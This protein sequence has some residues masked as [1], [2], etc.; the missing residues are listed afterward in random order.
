VPE[1]QFKKYQF[2]N[3]SFVDIS[4]A[5]TGCNQV[6]NLQVSDNEP[7]LKQSNPA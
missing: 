4:Q 5:S 6:K 2:S 3:S 7:N 1:N